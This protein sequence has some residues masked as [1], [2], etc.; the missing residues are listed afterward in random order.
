M[1]SAA[2]FTAG[3]RWIL[4]A[5]CIELTRSSATAEAAFKRIA[6]LLI[7]G[8]CTRKK[9]RFVKQTVQQTHCA[10]LLPL[11]WQPAFLAAP[12][13]P[14]PPLFSAQGS[15]VLSFLSFLSAICLPVSLSL[16]LSCVCV[17][18]CVCVPSRQYRF[19]FLPLRA[20]FH[21]C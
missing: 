1:T 12:L 3:C 6:E 8:I 4:A 18:V 20:P 14:P 21:R 5:P 16:C 15:P 13:P 17:C 11:G 9:K 2:I 7:G 19:N 10:P